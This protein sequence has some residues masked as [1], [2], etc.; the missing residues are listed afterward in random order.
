MA[1]RAAFGVSAVERIY[2]N[3]EPG[4]FGWLLGDIRALPEPIGWR[5]GQSFFTVPDEAFPAD[6]RPSSGLLL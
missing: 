2:G 6:F 5:G 4:R 3:Y 1:A